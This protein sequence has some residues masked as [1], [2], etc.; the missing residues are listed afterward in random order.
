MEDL[1]VELD[2][3]TILMVRNLILKISVMNEDEAVDDDDDDDYAD[4]AHG[5]KPDIGDFNNSKDE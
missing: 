3:L 2:L 4:D 1:E 5:E